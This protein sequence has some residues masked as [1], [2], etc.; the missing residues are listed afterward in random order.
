MN[1]EGLCAVRYPYLLSL[2]SVPYQYLSSV[3]AYCQLVPWTW[4]WIWIW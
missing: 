3:R 2:D 4:T 1:E